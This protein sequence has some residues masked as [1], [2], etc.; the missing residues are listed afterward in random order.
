MADVFARRGKLQNILIVC[1]DK[2]LRKDVAKVLG[3]ELDFLYV[4]V[5]EILDHQLLN[6]Q[7][8]SLSEAGDKLREL[9]RKSIKRAL[10]FDNCIITMSRNLFVANDNFL[11]LKDRIKIFLSVSKSHFISRSKFKDEQSLQ[12]EILMFDGI[13]KLVEINCNFKIENVNNNSNL[14]SENI[15]KILK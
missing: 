3:K 5:D 8:I 4:D 2:D 13:N 12:Q 6:N 1:A 11:M 7:H 14:I 10:E 9:E 15:L